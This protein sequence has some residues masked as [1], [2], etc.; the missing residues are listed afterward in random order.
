MKGGLNLSNFATTMKGGSNGPVVI[1]GKSAE[2]LI[3]SL[4]VDGEMPGDDAEPVPEVELKKLAAWID[5]ADFPSS[6]DLAEEA[7]HSVHARAETLWSF[8]APVRPTLPV[9]HKNTDRVRT[10]VDQFL[11]ARLEQEGVSYRPEAEKRVA[12][13]RLYFDLIGLP[14]SPRDVEA[15]L[16][17]TRPDAWEQ[18]VDRLLASPQYGERWGRHWLDVAGWSESTLLIQ[19]FMRPGFWSYRDWVIQAFNRDLPYNEFVREQIAGDE[20]TDWRNADVLTPDMLDK[21][22]ATGFLRST[23]DGTDNQLIT[24]EEKRFATQQTA[25]EVANKALMG[26]TL[27]CVRCHDHKYD[28]ITQKEY[29]QTISIFSAAYDL[30]KWLPGMVNTFGAGP[31]RVVPVADKPGRAAFSERMKALGERNAELSYQRD[32]GIPNRYRDK[33]VGE[34]MDKLPPEIDRPLL[35]EALTKEERERNPEQKAVVYA[36]AKLFEL[37]AENIKKL[38]PTIAKEQDENQKQ[39]R[40][41]ADEGSDIGQVIWALWDVSTDPTPLRLLRRGD[42]K[43]PA[44]VVEPGVIQMLD[45]PDH[46]WTAPSFD[47]QHDDTTGRR[48]AYADWLVR[49][50]HPLTARVMV[51]RIWQYHFGTGIVSTPDDFGARGAKPSHPELLDWLATEF[52][53]SGWS[54]KHLHRLMVNSSAYRQA[55]LSELDTDNAA[56][57]LSPQLL[58]SFP[59]RRIE[60]EA[61]RDS[62]LAVSGLL[63]PTMFGESI[64]T[65]A[66]SDGSYSVPKDHPGRHRRSIYLSTRR[67]QLPTLLQLF[68]APSMD[69]NWPQRH[70]S[71]IAPQALAMTNDPFVIE[72][73]DALAGRILRERFSTEDRIAHAF[74]IC[75]A[76]KPDPDEVKLVSEMVSSPLDRSSLDDE[77]SL[78]R[79]VAH[80]LVASNE[81][82]YVD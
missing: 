51:N 18:C 66:Q 5:G 67:T 82:I 74:E 24:Q 4:V 2:S 72:C 60:A 48:L 1:P 36:A 41:L 49:P 77:R 14:P 23:P 28:P 73:A 16:A 62:L 52:V 61:M 68:D 25:V 50:K 78:W 33:Y 10:P 75:Y 70:D 80:A 8:H 20:L 13:R 17:D 32:N 71:A 54:I 79:S 59:R 47:P 39:Q 11:L 22:T 26:L 76:R 7:N 42:F 31:V 40:R 12:L 29:Y 58:A 43:T 55:S 81:F 38:Y 3:Y 30:E 63:N 6:A 35:K 57:E 9:V 64:A 27:N 56:R 53:E 44:D 65:V 69:T 15:Y 46:P 45:D 19:D 21:L 34:N 37:G